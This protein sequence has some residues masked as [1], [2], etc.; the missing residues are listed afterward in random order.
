MFVDKVR[1]TVIGGRGRALHV[2]AFENRPGAKIYD[3]ISHSF[4]DRRTFLW[5]C[6]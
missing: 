1:I 4:S 5:K 6:L 3:S 2:P